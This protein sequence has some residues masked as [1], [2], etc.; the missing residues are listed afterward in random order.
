MQILDGGKVT[1][2]VRRTTISEIESNE[3]FSALFMEYADECA[4]HGLPAPT[5]KMAAYHLIEKSGIFQAYGAFLGD[6]LI[7]F[8]AVLTPVVPHYGVGITVTESLFV[9]KEYRKMGAGLKLLKKAHNHASA[10]K[11]PGLFISAPTGGTLE[12]ILPRLGF[13]ETNKAFFKDIIYV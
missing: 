4:I 7:G 8:M 10:A 3:N 1:I 11:S 2:M 13:R 9:G 12:K 5:E 6:I